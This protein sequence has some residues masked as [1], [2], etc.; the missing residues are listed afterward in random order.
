MSEEADKLP[1]TSSLLLAMLVLLYC[2]LVLVLASYFLS[3]VQCLGGRAHYNIAS[4]III[5][6]MKIVTQWLSEVL[7]VS[8]FSK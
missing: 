4:I 2:M 6:I 3:S 5:I 8:V 1:R 7:K